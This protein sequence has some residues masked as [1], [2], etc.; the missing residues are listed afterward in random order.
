M[1]HDIHLGMTRQRRRLARSLVPLATIV[2]AAWLASGPAA[3]VPFETCV[4]GLRA[5]VLKSGVKADVVDAAFRDISFD[6]KAVRFSRNQPE[7]RL[8]I[9]D[10]MAFLVDEARIADGRKMV[11]VED[12]NLRAIEKTYGVDRFVLTALWG[13]ESDYGKIEGDF[14]LPQ[15]LASLACAG[16]RP[17]LF[18]T[19][20]TQVLKI[21]SAGDVKLK[22]LHGSWAGAF[23]HTQFMP[24]TYRRLAVDFDRDGRKDTINSV[25]DALASSA[26][27]LRKAGW[28]SGLSW[29]F[30]VKLP[31][32]YKGPTGRT[33][34]AAISAW[35]K[36]GITRAD[37]AALPKS[38]A[39][40]LIRPGGRSGPAFLV[41]RNFDALYSYNAAESY[42]LAI[43]HLSDRLKGKSAFAT[44]WPTDDPGLSRAERKRLQE[45]LI[46]QGLYKGEADGRMG[47]LTSAA[48]K[49]AEKKAGLKETGR[50]GARI[51]KVLAG[52]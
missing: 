34:K 36:R 17:G 45:L 28:R 33:R 2:L 1:N 38:G 39:Y 13:V 51:L 4:K 9:W 41:S 47:P 14:F 31:T 49:A 27:F 37:G 30:E 10:Y 20:L 3:A 43:S 8:K 22:D 7:Y 29:G 12:K 48:I 25:P 44:K 46:A 15:A 52:N 35:A 50:P 26:N 5:N 42:A 24:S 16:R 23:G 11:Q 18:R 40:G 19:E 21:V 32:S 6:E